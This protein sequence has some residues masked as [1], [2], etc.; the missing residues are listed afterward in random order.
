MLVCLGAA[1][2]RVA[3][4]N[5]RRSGPV[6]LGGAAAVAI[7]PPDRPDPVRIGADRGGSAALSST[8]LSIVGYLGTGSM[9]RDPICAVHGSRSGRFKPRGGGRGP[10]VSLKEKA[11]TGRA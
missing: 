2:A 11:R 9:A 8:S 6:Q 5:M 1:A 4:T 3:L 7:L 10:Q